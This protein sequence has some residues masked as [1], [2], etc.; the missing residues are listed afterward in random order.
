MTNKVGCLLMAFVLNIFFVPLKAQDLNDQKEKQIEQII[1]SI[2]GSDDSEEDNPLIL[3]DITKYSENPL[4]INTASAEELERLNI[5]DFSQ[6]NNLLAYRK[7]YGYIL[8]SYEL[9]AV[10]GLTPEIIKALE[11]FVSFGQPDTIKTRRVYQKFLI[12]GKTSLPVARGYSSVSKTK[13]AAYS[14]IPVGLYSRYNLEIPGKLEAGFIT[15]HDAG[16]DFFKGSNPYGFDYY[17]GFIS[18]QSKS[19]IHQIIVGDYY[20]R[21]GQGLNFWSGGGIGKSAN[22]LNIFKSGQ[23]IRPY[24]STDEN[25]FFRGIATVLGKGPLKLMLFY[26]NK[27]RDANTV[28]DKKSGE[29]Y[30]TSLETSGYHRTTSEIEDEKDLREQDAGAYSELRL[31]KFRLGAQFSYQHFGLNMTTGTEAYKSK[32]F[33]GH[34]NINTGI[35]YQLALRQIQLFGEVGM[36]LNLK[37]AVVQ[38][39][40]W[41][42]HPQFSLSLYY[43]YFDPGFHTFYGNALSEGSGC[44]NE[45]GF[46]TGIELNPLP[47]VNV[48]CYADFYH[49]P[50]LTYSTLAPSSGNDFMIQV[51]LAFLKNLDIY[52]K[53]KFET[54]SQ[55]ST[56]AAGNPADYDES[57]NKIRLNTEWKLS[58]KL[59]FKNRIEYAGYTFHNLTENGYLIYQDVVYSPFTK[60]DLC[61]RYAW[62]N[63]DGY[64]SRIYTYENDLLYGF[65]IPEFHGK[66]HR[67]YLNLKWKPSQS[68]TTY[69]KVGYTIHSGEDSWGSGNDLTMGNSRTELRAEIYYRF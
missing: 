8:S 25:Q 69:F 15:D 31:D 21:F 4:N 34:E 55:K 5:I 26:S 63:T 42:A 37:S 52:L 61:I 9:S 29:K 60:F 14:G 57:T 32:N 6:I 59:I 56:I 54:K 3:E 10:D 40:I 23:G 68:L 66:G 18:W 27:M 19:F 39:L 13:S 46:Y 49:F 50:W 20:L 53:G 43:R 47:K 33:T 7:Q 24:T 17:S 48:S 45:S 41:H 36:S 30:F 22:A 16:E 44:H 12:R 62:F 2:A 51:D 28:V 65:A 1:E 67:I 38:G 64:N 58:D 11:P 35:D